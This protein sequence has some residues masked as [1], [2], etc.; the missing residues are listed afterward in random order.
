MQYFLADWGPWTPV[1]ELSEEVLQ[2]A[3]AAQ[4]LASG[5]RECEVEQ[6]ELARW[7]GP[8]S[9]GCFEQAWPDKDHDLV[10][11]ECKVLVNNFQGYGS[12]SGYCDSFGLGCT[13]AWEEQNDDCT[14]IRQGDCDSSSF[15]STSDALCGGGLSPRSWSAPPSRRARAV[16]A[17]SGGQRG[18]GGGL[19]CG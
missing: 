8:A 3:R 13:G 16:A 17:G 1:W 5:Q 11:T 4:S 15:G 10:C 7:G 12:C 19:A 9:G 6:R 14:V 18:G 2:K